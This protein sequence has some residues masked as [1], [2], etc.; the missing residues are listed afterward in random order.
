MRLPD[1]DLLPAPSLRRMYEAMRKRTLVMGILNVT[2]D[3][4]SDGGLHTDA[5]EAVR[6][7]L[8]MEKDGADIID[9]G[10]ESTRPG[11]GPVSAT[12][13][14]DRVRPVIRELAARSS[15]PISIDT[16]KAE[17]A[18]AAVQAGALIINDITGLQGGPELAGI[19]GPRRLPLILMHMQG[20][21]RTM[22]IAPRYDDLIGEIKAF[23]AMQMQIA[24]SAGVPPELLII[25]PGFGFGKTLEHN[26]QLLKRLAEFR[27][28]GRP[29]L[30][31]TSRKSSLA[32][33][34]PDAGAGDRLET[35][36][37]TVAVSVVNGANIVRVHD[38]RA[39][40]R[41]ARM[42]DAIVRA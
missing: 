38:V 14:I 7:A 26:L 8:Q 37:A 6:F 5:N 34:V 25:D 15:V 13:E 3:S 20:T 11:A 10:G 27:S 23:L 40:V 32:R 2:P 1:S 35:T 9:I 28:L 4:F 29:I 21:P 17:V 22:Q 24:E 33:V 41:V 42:T 39:M 18:E 19:A 12:H 36:S 31:G 16:S 30:I